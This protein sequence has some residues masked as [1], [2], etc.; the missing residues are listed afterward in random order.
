M[1]SL[2]SLD[3]YS[4]LYKQAEL[5]IVIQIWKY[6]CWFYI[7]QEGSLISE[8]HLPLRKSRG[9]H[10]GWWIWNQHSGQVRKCIGE[11]SDGGLGFLADSNVYLLLADMEW[12][13]THITP[14]N[15]QSKKK[16]NG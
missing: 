11:M 10:E 12:P 5:S 6:L 3:S 9:E 13:L 16:G 15:S 8:I 2:K 4:L 1:D 7:T 14:F